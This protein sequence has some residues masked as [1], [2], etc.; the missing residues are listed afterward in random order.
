MCGWYQIRNIL[1]VDYDFLRH[2]IS[3][4]F[5]VGESSFRGFMAISKSKYFTSPKQ[6]FELERIFEIKK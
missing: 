2:I 5:R 1:C 3:H 6:A 4:L